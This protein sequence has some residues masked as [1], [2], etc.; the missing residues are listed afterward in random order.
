MA[1]MKCPECGKEVS[2]KVTV[3]PDCGSKFSLGETVV[4]RS[5]DN[6]VPEDEAMIVNI[7]QSQGKLSAVKWY[8]EKYFCDLKEAKDAVDE[9]VKKH[10]PELTPEGA[11]GRGCSIIVLIVISITLGAMLMM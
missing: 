3:C 11:G 6:N 4:R 9:I 7:I 1:L 5:G 2:D 8:R 10:V